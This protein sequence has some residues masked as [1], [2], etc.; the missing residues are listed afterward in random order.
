LTSPV[1]KTKSLANSK[2]GQGRER[3][4]PLSPCSELYS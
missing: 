2:P 4:I 1:T 3:P